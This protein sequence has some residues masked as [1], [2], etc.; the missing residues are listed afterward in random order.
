MDCRVMGA[1]FNAEWS[2]FCILQSSLCN[3]IS[4]KK[5]REVAPPQATSLNQIGRLTLYAQ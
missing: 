2:R 1:E 5:E 3:Q 4:L